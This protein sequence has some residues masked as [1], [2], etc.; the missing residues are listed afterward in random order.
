MSKFWEKLIRP[1]MFGLDAERAHEIGLHALKL[2][3]GAGSRTNTFAGL[4][5]I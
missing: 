3:I 5:E 4:G 1:I 2:G